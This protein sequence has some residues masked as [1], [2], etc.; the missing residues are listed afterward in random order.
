MT[1]LEA[2]VPIKTWAKDI[3]A[4]AYQQLVETSTLPF[5]HKHVAVMPDVHWGMGATIG[6]V[7]AMKKAIVPAAVG[8]DIGCGM[9]AL[10]TTL[11]ASDLP[12]SLSGLR[13]A[14]EEVVPVG[15]NEHPVPQVMPHAMI[16][17]FR[18]IVN[19]TPA[20]TQR[21]PEKYLRQMG[22]L[23][24][25]NH[26]IE[27]CL[28][29]N[30]NVWIMLHSGSRNVGKVIADVFISEA[31]A[32]R[33]EEGI[34]LPNKDLAYLVE[35]TDPFD[36]YWEA[37]DWAQ[38]YARMN[39]DV[40]LTHVAGALADATKPFE[41]RGKAVNCHHNYAVRE[42]HFGE[43]VILTRKGAVRAWMGDLVIIPGSMGARSFIA[44]GQG[45]EDS[46]HSCSHGAGRRMSRGDAK[47]AF[48][49]EDLANQ[50]QG[51]ECRKDAGVVDEIPAAYKDIDEVMEQQKDLVRPLVTLKQVLCVKG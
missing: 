45:N 42:T 20:I 26:F 5:L 47:R 8:V 35:G 14:I 4:K 23:G 27:I 13:S 6:S 15:F 50:T 31:K 7:L 39:R 33:E 16:N 29:E 19:Q 46:F 30:D 36:R 10:P 37:L 48:T 11:K 28:D 38:R 32:L 43:E 44:V 51:V 1:N 41:A 49:A 25:G 40:M 12:D 9:A 18:V 24:G 21:D 34:K 2:H 22:T 3:E 17:Q